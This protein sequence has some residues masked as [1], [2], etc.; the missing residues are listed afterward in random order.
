MISI[1]K[2]DFYFLFL[3]IAFVPIEYL[4]SEFKN[5]LPLSNG[6]L[7]CVIGYDNAGFVM[8]TSGE[9][10][11]APAQLVPFPAEKGPILMALGPGL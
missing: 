3:S 9:F 2:T 6:S 4:G 7:N 11:G 1:P 5:G 10:F 8:A